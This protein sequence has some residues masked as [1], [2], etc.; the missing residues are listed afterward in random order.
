MLWLVPSAQ[1]N[2]IAGFI[3]GNFG[4]CRAHR[5][6]PG[7]ARAV[8]AAFYTIGNIGGVGAWLMGPARVA[9]AIGLDRY[10]PRAFGKLH[11]K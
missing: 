6:W 4:R 11:P 1:V 2:L 8:A 9:F 3:Q 10:F 5:D 7:V